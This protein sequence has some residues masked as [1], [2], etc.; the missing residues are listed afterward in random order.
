MLRVL[1]SIPSVLTSR[2]GAWWSLAVAAVLL[3]LAMGALG[4]AD[5]DAGN[6]A[7]PPQSES[8]RAA[9][10]AD[11]FPGAECQTLL[12]V[13]SRDDGAQLTAGDTAALGTLI[14]PVG[15]ATGIA[16]LGPFPSDDGRAAVIQATVDVGADGDAKAA[17][18]TVRDAVAAHPIS[19]VAVQVT[20][21]PAF[22]VDVAAAFDGADFT[23]LL[24]TIVIVAL[25]LILTYRSPV[26]WMIP[27]VVVA[28]AD[29]LAGSAT[30][31]V[32]NALQLQFDTGIV[33]V[34]VF[35]AGTNYALLLVSRYREQL[36]VDTDH[37][38]A[39]A[40]AW[41]GTAGAIVAS[42]LTVVLSLATLVLAV[43]PGTRGLGVASAVGLLIALVA[44]LFLLP[45]LLAVCGRGVFWPFV[46]RPDRPREY[47]R[48]WRGVAERV[49]RRPWLPLVGGAV[50]L[51]VMAA[52][53]F[54]TTVGLTQV[55]KFRVPSESA[56]GLT[57][58][59]A[60]FDPG[61]AQADDRDRR[62]G[63]GGCRHRRDRGCSRRRAGHGIRHQRR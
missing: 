47:G 14:D 1:R 27:L 34:L 12:I 62:H 21:G 31:A 43:I 61:L 54:G 18:T 42:N 8:A 36:A 60:H 55:E 20:G 19:G 32:G 33:S 28:L 24:V 38:R 59:G 63:G 6:E 3:V 22:G 41:R 57:V 49:V 26:L 23:L 37:R 39:L 40:R 45:P 29:E 35:G 51:G 15:T 25:L 10:A 30:V 2:R 44:V 48:A 4:R 11:R 53:L 46:P 7:A 56:A 13:A 50:L 5:L 58:L 52:G 16:P 17:V 9:T